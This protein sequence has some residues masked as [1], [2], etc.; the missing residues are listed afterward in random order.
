MANPLLSRYG[1]GSLLQRTSAANLFWVQVLMVA[2]GV[3]LLGLTF[4][5]PGVA[6]YGAV[7]PL[8]LLG[9]TVASM[10]ALVLLAQ[11]WFRTSAWVTFLALLAVVVVVSLVSR[12]GSTE[13]DLFQTTVLFFLGLLVLSAVGIDLAQSLAWVFTGA[14]VF[15]WV[16][17]VPPHDMRPELTIGQWNAE[18]VPLVVATLYAVGSVAGVL[19]LAQSRKNLKLMQFDQEIIENSNQML[20]QT[21]ADR[22]KALQTILDSSGQGLFTFGADFVIEGDFSAG[23]R[24]IFGRDIAGLEAPRLLFPQQA[25]MARE[26]RQG[27]EIY[28]AGRSRAAVIFDLLEKETFIAGRFLT[29][30]YK[31]AG[32][33]K[34]LVVLTDVTLDRQLSDRNRADEARRT[35][36]LRA[37]GHKRFFAD[38]IRDAE[39]LFGVLRIYEDR[40]ATAEES[41]SL[42]ASIHTFKGN[43]GFFGFTLTQEVAHDFEYAIADSQVLGEEL[44]YHDLSLDLKRAYYQELGVIVDALGR[45]WI[46]EAGGIVIARDVYDKVAKYVAKK[47]PG[48]VNL[49]DVLEH[50]RKMPMKD[51]FSRFP[52]IAQATAEKLG[53]RIQ[54]MEVIGGELRVVPERLERLIASFVHVVNNMVDHGIELPYVREA[55]GKKPEGKLSVT[56]TREVSSVVIQFSDDGQGVSLAEVEA[57]AKEKGLLAADA[58]PSPREV[59]QLLFEPGFSTRAEATEVS[60]RG[61]GLAAVRQE[62]ERLGG[63]VEVNTKLNA[64]TT[65]EIILPLGVFANRRVQKPAPG[66]DRRKA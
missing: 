8:V 18:F 53:K 49:V 33:G 2:S 22:T 5:A 38:L 10:G 21:V 28:F 17:L 20:E 40:P 57:R 39:S 59:L 50:F 58:T 52:F 37:L 12:S 4:A 9:F 64:G 32:V 61:I 26:F 34:I 1:Q 29:I 19:I 11:G 41:Q 55:Q 13:A 31:E 60:G 42:L 48:E 62:A 65:F 47:Y 35:L 56:I 14:G 25:D 46:D 36:V 3:V 16:V 66:P 63:R 30:D 51:L 27:L 43:C 24:T 44:D 7:V 15:V 54:P 23:C 45:G 6:S